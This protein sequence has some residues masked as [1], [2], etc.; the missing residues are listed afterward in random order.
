MLIHPQFGELLKENLLKFR[1]HKKKHG[2][3]CFVLFN[4][5]AI[6]VIYTQYSVTKQA[7]FS[8]VILFCN[9]FNKTSVSTQ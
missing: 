6:L 1:F 5:K 3:F 8:E 2:L 9:T 7:E 4:L